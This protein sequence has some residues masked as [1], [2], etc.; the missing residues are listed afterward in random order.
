MADR[1]PAALGPLLG[2]ARERLAT[3]GIDDPGLDS[4]LIV[5]HFSGTTRTQAI[6]D[7]GQK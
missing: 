2:A 7:P 6:A 3:A 4:R 1:L 5:E